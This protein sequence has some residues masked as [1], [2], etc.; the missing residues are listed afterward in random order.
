MS[1]TDKLKENDLLRR[2]VKRVKIYREFCK[3]A[4]AFSRY[5]LEEAEKRGDSRYRILLLVHR[6]EKGMCRMDLRPFG[7]KKVEE[8]IAIL[9][10][11]PNKK[12]FEYHIGCETLKNWA[13][14]FEEHGWESEEGYQEVRKF[15][16]Q[17]TVP[18][19]ND[20]TKIMRR[21]D[22]T[23]ESPF[24]KVL[25][26]RHSVRDFQ[27][28]ELREEDIDFALR[29]FA[30]APTACNRQMCRVY[31]IKSPKIKQILDNT[32]IGIGG[33]HK[34]AVHYFVVTYDIAAFEYYGERN[35]GYLNAG[36]TSM[37]FVN[38][39]HARGIGSC[40]LQW[41][42]KGR[43]DARVRAAMGIS[44]SERIAVVIGA[45]YYLDS[46]RIPQSRRKSKNDIYKVIEEA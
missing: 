20:A 35:Q 32:I 44:K 42:N 41:S 24:E 26:S 12:E 43:E 22:V 6:I 40:F 16:E 3:D 9:S 14:F 27:K 25:F 21:P 38:G 7:H 2:T 15:L 34:A 13:D 29:C 37:N 18:I 23:E 31:Y 28:E 11:Y 46:L 39:L 45:G 17:C 5:Y 36:L 33:F 1:L 30:E 19:Q 10:A 4:A 8:L